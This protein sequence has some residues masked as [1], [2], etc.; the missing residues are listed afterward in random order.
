MTNP[1]GCDW[2]KPPGCHCP[3]LR[4]A[5]AC[6]ERCDDSLFELEPEVPG[7]SLFLAFQRTVLEK[8]CQA[9]GGGKK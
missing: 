3:L 9:F 6:Y 1:P 2:P 4:Q 7:D 8:I 5:Q